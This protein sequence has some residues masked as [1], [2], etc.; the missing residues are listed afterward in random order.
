MDC[1]YPQYLTFSEQVLKAQRAKLI[2]SY[3]GTLAYAALFARD[4]TQ[5][6]IIS[7]EG[8][9]LFAKDFQIF[10]RLTYFHSLWLGYSRLHELPALLGYAIRL[11][12]E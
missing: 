7:E 8:D 2:V 3:H 1:F 12:T 11:L 5:V 9:G 10:S 6:I 4:G